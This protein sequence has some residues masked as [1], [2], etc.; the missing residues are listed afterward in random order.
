MKP[1]DIEQLASLARI[2]LTDDE[3]EQLAS[4]LPAIVEYVSVISDLTSEDETAEPVAGAVHNVLRADVV[5]NEPEQFTA[6]MIK[7]MPR[8]NGRFLA[9]KK[10]LQTDE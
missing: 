10:I 1:V 5:T 6:D 3:L 2:R 4:E 7:E 8:S 9:V